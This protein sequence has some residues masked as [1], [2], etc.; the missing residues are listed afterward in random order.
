[1][2][3]WENAY[4]SEWI[5][6]RQFI[7]NL[8]VIEMHVLRWMRYNYSLSGSCTL[9]ARNNHDSAICKYNNGFGGKQRGLRY[10]YI[11]FEMITS[12]VAS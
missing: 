10:L 5:G 8:S 7:C 6:K 11:F 1:M 12:F 3:N 4:S 2:L 9:L